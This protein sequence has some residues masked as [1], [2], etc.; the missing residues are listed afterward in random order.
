M[1]HMRK[2]SLFLMGIAFLLA[3]FLPITAGYAGTISS[4]FP[5]ATSAGEELSRS[6]AFDGTNYLVGIQG[7][8]AADYNITAQLVSQSGALV[9]SR[10]STS[11]TGGA[12]LVAFDGTNYLMVWADDA[13]Y[14]HDIIYGQLIS[15]A[16]ATVESP[17]VIG[18]PSG[19]YGSPVGVV[20]DGSNYFVAWNT[21]DGGDAVDLYGQ[22]IS[23]SGS[24]LGSP[25]A[26]TT[27]IYQQRDAALA[28]DG[29]NILVVWADGRRR[30][31]NGP[32]PV[33]YGYYPTD[34][35]G[36]F[37]TKSGEGSAGS[38]FGSNFII[39]ENSYPSDNPLN[40]AF[41][42]TNYLVVWMDEVI[43]GTTCPDYEEIGGQWDLFGQ[44]IDKSGSKVGSVISVST[45]SGQQFA[46]SIAFDGTN[47]L[48]SW[49]DMR[50]DANGNWTCDAEEGTCSDIYGQFVSKSGALL[51]SEFIINNDEGNQLGGFGGYAVNGKLF[52][53]I[54]TGVDLALDLW[55]DVYGVFIS[56]AET[57]C[58]FDGDGDSDIGVWRPS[59][60]KW[61]IQGQSAV[62][63]GVSTD[64]PVPGDYDGDGDSGIAV[65]RPSNGK[66]LIQ[67]QSA[68]AWGVST[69]IPVP[70][71]YDGDGDTEIGVWRPSNGKWY[72][73]GMSSTQ[74]GVS[75]DWPVAQNIWILKQT[76]LIP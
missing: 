65:W 74:W 46:P 31:H 67:G 20:F 9:G 54:N 22:F 6:A 47:Y 3:A 42:G 73:Q 26:I 29:T 13:T 55:G 41:D 69:D 16:G 37:V 59:N 14:P 40:I 17:F 62:A 19:E 23:P 50:N 18:T 61:Y 28:F 58:D 34:I 45:A 11:R 51:G 25:V 1:S 2:N 21:A 48:V 4:E 39:N 44:L 24:L 30:I 63:W 70:G 49:T 8:E 64:C 27:A 76:G 75:T 60:G 10:I 12:P 43:M 5:I 35:Y 72:I 56:S 71:D 66:W 33:G 68:I 38:L 52:G 32:C 57:P 7:D 15:K 36:Q 53:L